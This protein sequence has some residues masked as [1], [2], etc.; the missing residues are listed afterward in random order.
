MIVVRAGIVVLA[1]AAIAWL[2]AGLA[3]TRA[4]DELSR[5]V[6]VTED[7]TAARIARAA[8]LRRDAERWAPG[9][10]ASL[11]EATM[12][13]NGGDAEGAVRLLGDVVRDEPEN[14]EGW[15]LLARAAA[16]RDPALADRAMA[17]VRVLAPEVPP[18]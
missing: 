11:L 15:L 10:R 13:L 6:A 9:R 8:D 4:Q 18:P 7:P 16:E 5:L 2:A 14:G 17:R 12:R 1:V 3:A